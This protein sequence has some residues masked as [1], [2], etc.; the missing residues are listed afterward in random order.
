MIP[1]HGLHTIIG[2]GQND[3]S[4]CRSD[5]TRYL[6]IH[7]RLP[8]TYDKPGI[9]KLPVHV[10][11]MCVHLCMCSHEPLSNSYLSITDKNAGL[12]GVCL[13][14]VPLYTVCVAYV[15]LFSCLKMS[16]HCN[17][18]LASLL[19]TI[20]RKFSR[21]HCGV[22]YFHLLGLVLPMVVSILSWRKH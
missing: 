15:P 3:K 17:P 1:V 13:R 18:E 14:G 10:L 6:T 7:E 4:A 11:Y 19:A 5:F 16:V 12:N 8:H 22:T 9:I 2:W 20:T 21:T